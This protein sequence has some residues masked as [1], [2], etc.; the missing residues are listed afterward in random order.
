MVESIK[1]GDELILIKPVGVSTV[2]DQNPRVVNDIVASDILATNLYSLQG[3]DN[4]FKRPVVWRKQ[5]V[6]RT[7]DGRIIPKTREALEPQIYPTARVIGSASTTQDFLFLDNASL[8]NYEAVTPSTNFDGIITQGEDPVVGILSVG[9]G[10]TGASAG[11]ISTI[12]VLNGGSGY[13]GIVTISISNPPD[14]TVGFG[15]T[16]L[17]TAIISNGS[18]IGANITNAGSGYGT[19]AYAIVPNPVV[20][21]E[22]VT[23]IPTVNG[24]EGDIIGITTAVGIGT[25]LS[26]KFTLNLPP[27]P[28]DT[29]RDGMRIFVNDTFVGSGLTSIDTNNSQIIGIGT[30]ACNN[31]YKVHQV[32]Y[33]AG[34]GIITAFC[35]IDSNSNVS[36]INTVGFAFTSVGYYSWGIVTGFSRGSEPI[37]L[38]VDGNTFSVGL[39]SYPLFQRRGFGLRGTGGITK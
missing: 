19:S 9:V 2:P 31:I 37:A 32:Q 3:I 4:N 26:L 11:T 38:N 10:T 12:T 27:S 6:D 34:N 22:P 39:G 29:L 14:I 20:K 8:F 7:V 16:A 15:T 35:N 33:D 23:L 1:I 17:A 24:Y 5:K 30:T 25:N 28:T 18:I 36:G 21:I 13:T